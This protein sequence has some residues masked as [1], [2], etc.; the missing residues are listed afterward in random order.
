MQIELDRK[1]CRT[2]VE[3]ADAIFALLE[4]F[5]NR[6]R[7]HSQLGYSTPI[8]NELRVNQTSILA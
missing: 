5:Y 7:R 8:E 4:I 3:L 2:R 6:Q 1:N